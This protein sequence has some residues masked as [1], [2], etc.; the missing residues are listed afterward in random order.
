VTG[1]VK[2][3]LTL[4]Y[5]DVLSLSTSEVT[6]T[7]DCTGGWCTVQTWRGI[8]LPQLLSQAEITPDAVGIILR[9]VMD[10]TAPFT[11]AQAEEISLA[12]HVSG[13]VLNHSHGFPLR[14][15]VPSRRG[16]HW[17][18]WMTEIEVRTL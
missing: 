3:P 14:A 12:T 8:A 13:E 4:T 7:L 6:T 16:W 2:T 1:A 17:V 9:G 18:K 5:A 10:Y 15:V 11:L